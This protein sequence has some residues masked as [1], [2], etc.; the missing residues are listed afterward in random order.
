MGTELLQSPFFAC[1]EVPMGDL[2]I[3]YRFLLF[4]MCRKFDFRIKRT[5]EGY[6]VRHA[7]FTDVKFQVRFVYRPPFDSLIGVPEVNGKTY[8]TQEDVVSILNSRLL[9]EWTDFSTPGFGGMEHMTSRDFDA[10]CHLLG[11]EEGHHE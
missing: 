3:T 8:M 9:G 4:V 2:V 10:V 11:V 1:K 7:L 6:E 5:P